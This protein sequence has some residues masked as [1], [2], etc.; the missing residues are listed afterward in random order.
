MLAGSRPG[1]SGRRPSREVDDVPVNVAS[2]EIDRAPLRAPGASMPLLVNSR[3]DA[4]ATCSARGGRLCTELEWERACEGEDHH[5]FLTGPALDLEG[6]TLDLNAC[7]SSFGVAAMGI[8][9]PEWTASDLAPELVAVGASAVVRGARFDQ[10]IATHRCDARAALSPVSEIGAAVRCCYGGDAAGAYPPP[11][12][13]PVFAEAELGDTE[14]RAILATIPEL[15]S[16]ATDFVVH[17]IADGD[18]ALARGNA[19]R[20]T[21]AGWELADGPFYWSPTPGD[22]VLVL[23]GHGGGSTVIAALYR[24]PDGSHVHGGSFVLEG[25]DAPVAISRTPPSRGELKWT[26]CEG[27]GGESGVIRLDEDQVVRVLQF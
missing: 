14:V 4:E 8:E 3:A 25:E 24:M 18:R 7:T 9:R 19:T 13:H 27:C 26:A 17:G 15:R 22:E 23:S 2:F 12:S 20:E 6:C 16:Y 1:T 5:P 21:L 11:T 10:P